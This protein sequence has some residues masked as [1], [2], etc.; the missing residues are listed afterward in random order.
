MP[1]KL[2]TT[3]PVAKLRLKAATRRSRSSPR[4]WAQESRS[5]RTARALM[6]KERCLSSR[7]PT[8]ISSPM[9]YAPNKTPILRGFLRPFF[10]LLETADVLAVHKHLRHG[11]AAG[12]GADDARAVAVVEAHLRVRVAE[13]FEERLRPRAVAAALAREDR[14]L[15][16]S[17]RLGIDV[18]QHRVGIRHLERSSRLFRLD[19]HLL[20]HAVLDEHR[21]VPR[22][23]AEAE[24]GLVD[25][26][27]HLLGELAVA[28]RKHED[29]AG[30]L[31]ARPFVHDE[32]VVDRDTYDAIDAVGEQRRRELVVARHVRRG[33]GRRERSRQ[34]EHH[35]GLALEDLVGADGLPVAL[36]AGAE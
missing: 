22:A 8:R 11:A 4:Y 18:V 35:D 24:L 1:P 33:A 31:G 20:D 21:V 14:H 25:Q 6:R 29:V 17:I 36:G 13:L 10:E 27:A 26:H 3:S 32:G 34:R 16:R 5:P 2:N 23:L 19:E 12:D 28:V 7:L 30:F 15:V 9:M